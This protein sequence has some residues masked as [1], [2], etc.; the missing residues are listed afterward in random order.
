MRALVALKK[1][2]FLAWTKAAFNLWYDAVT[3]LNDL[4]LVPPM[5]VAADWTSILLLPDQH[6]KKI[7]FRAYG[8]GFVLTQQLN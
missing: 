3:V 2:Q 8:L 4:Y 1:S 6:L 5:T 7:S